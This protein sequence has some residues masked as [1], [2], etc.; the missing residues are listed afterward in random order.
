MAIT[1]AIDAM[2][3]DIGLDVTVPAALDTVRRVAD[4]KL[5]LVGPEDEIRRR[6]QGQGADG[7]LE[8]AAATE[9]VGMDEPVAQALRSKKNSSMR[10]AIDQVKAGRADACVSAGNTGALMAT[11][12]FVLRTLPGIDRP[13]IATALPRASGHVHVLDLGANVDVPAPILLQFGVM[14]ATLVASVSGVE[15]PT[16]GLL[17]VGVEDI[18]GND[19]IR[20]ASDLFRQSTLNYTG[21]VEGDDIFNG[22]VDVIVC[23]GF[24]GNV[25][26]KTAEG[27]AQMIG[28]VLRE[29]FGRNLLTRLAAVSALPVLKSVR[30]R[31]DHRHYNGASLVGLR[32]TVVK[33]HGGADAVGFARAIDVAIAEVRN[34]VVGHLEAALGSHP[35]ASAG[36]VAGQ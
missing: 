20:Q 13:A 28:A 27:L 11:A 8:V 25:A 16:V 15:N 33:S 7:R 5:I 23:D 24:S 36:T 19:T 21:F 29:E 30:R 10:V 35:G 4:A 3:G 9:V 18:K 32:G 34:N 31:M 26:L 22:K 1:I 2:G 17:N 6:L 14:G 12:R